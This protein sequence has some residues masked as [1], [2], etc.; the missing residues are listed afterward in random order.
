MRGIKQLIA[1]GKSSYDDFGLYIKERNP[2]LPKKRSNKQTIPGMHGS[3]DFS[4]LYGEIIYEDRK[5]EYKFDITGWDI[6]DLDTER[7]KVYDWILNIQNTEI[8]DEYCSNYHWLGS[9]DDGSWKEDAEQGELTITFSVYPF[10]ISNNPI[11]LYLTAT[12]TK[13]N[14]EIDNQ[15]SHRISP[16]IITDGNILIEYNNKTFNLSSG[17]WN[18]SDFYFNKGINNIVISGS[19]NVCI[20]YNEEVF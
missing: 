1:N 7:R 18:L 4:M 16:T 14:I 12:N 9:Y 10:L 6:A 19:A 8:I 17:V 15:S 5:I 13:Q 2:S 11:E 20:K 3:Y